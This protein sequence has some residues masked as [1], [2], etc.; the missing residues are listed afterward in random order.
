MAMVL[1]RLLRIRSL[2]EEA[3]RAELERRV[4]ESARVDR[5][6]RR[7]AE[8]ARQLRYEGLAPLLNCESTDCGSTDS[9][10]ILA[11]QGRRETEAEGQSRFLAEQE[12]ATGA[13][14][15]RQ[16][17]R[18]A[19]QEMQRVAASREEF[20][21]R[22]K[23]RRQVEMLLQSEARDRA[24]DEARRE[25]RHLDDW[26]AAARARPGRADKTG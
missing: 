10:G 16:L 24:V 12:R 2:L 5:A 26:F 1:K 20:L 11:E 8:G 7:E 22:R 18:M 14:R 13:Q 3:S 4:I 25:Q 6:L 23:E 17:E 9:G 19:A 21:A 15:R